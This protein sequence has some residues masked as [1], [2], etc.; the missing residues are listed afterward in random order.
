MAK[1]IIRLTNNEALIKIEGAAG[2]NTISLATDLL[3]AGEALDGGTQT[4]TITNVTWTTNGGT[5]TIVRNGVTLVSSSAP[6]GHLGPQQNFFDDGGKTSDIVVTSA[7]AEVQVWI[8][9]HKVG[10]F[11]TKFEPEQ[12]GSYDN[13]AASGS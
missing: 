2:T 3:G 5:F 13:P 7:T 8:R 11:K 1:R 12:F 6:V 4:A 9:V 10:G